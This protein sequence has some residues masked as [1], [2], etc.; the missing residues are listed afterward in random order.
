MPNAVDTGVLRGRDLANRTTKNVAG[1]AGVNITLDDL[2]YGVIELIG[3]ITANIAVIF[4]AI[5]GLFV[6]VF[7]NTT[8]AFVITAKIGSSAGI[9]ALQGKR[10]FLYLDGS[11][12]HDAAGRKGTSVGQSI[13]VTGDTSL[14]AAQAAKSYL[15]LTDGGLS[16]DF[17]LTIPIGSMELGDVIWI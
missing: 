17:V 11:E 7:N 3:A 12:V 9:I 16:A 6:E 13:S 4:P 15:S 10:Q 2:R 8:G 1:A 14:T 5:D